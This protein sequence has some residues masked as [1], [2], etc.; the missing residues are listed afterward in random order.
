MLYSPVVT[1]YCGETCVYPCKVNTG[2]ELKHEKLNLVWFSSIL[3]D[4]FFFLPAAPNY[5]WP[6]AHQI[7]N[8]L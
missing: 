4:L 7:L 2:V 6:P 5:I 3:F 1:Q 8:I